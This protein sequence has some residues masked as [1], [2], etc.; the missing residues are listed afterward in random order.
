ML[1]LLR[2]ALKK[3]TF[4]C[5]LKRTSHRLRHK[6][7]K[8]ISLL[9][10]Y[11]PFDYKRFSVGIVIIL[12]PFMLF[13]QAKSQQNTDSAKGITIH[14]EINFRVSS[15]IVYDALLSSKQFSDITKKSFDMFTASSATID[16]KI[17]GAFSVFDG[18]II[19]TIIELVPNERI[20]EAWR[21]VDWP[22]GVYSIAR[23]EL[24]TQGT[25]THLIFDQVGFPEG[26]KAHLALGWQ[27]HYWDALT[28]YFQ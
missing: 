4:E 27:Q 25:G 21:V 17:G 6:M 18:H 20:V 13:A 7:K 11:I 16:A 8:M 22:A 1:P 10:E 24:R 12:L 5:L 26:L 14:Q 15:Q 2:D 9:D 19:G 23:F 28:K 3:R